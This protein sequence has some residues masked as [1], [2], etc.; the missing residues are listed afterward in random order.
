MGGHMAQ[1]IA[2]LFL[3]S[4]FSSFLPAQESSIQAGIVQFIEGETFMDGNIFQLAKDSIRL[5]QTGQTLSTKQG[6]LE[7][8]LASNTNLSLGENTSLRMEQSNSNGAILTLEKGSI[9]IE[10]V[11]KHTDPVRV[12]ILNSTVEIRKPGLYRLDF[13]PCDLRVYRGTALVDNGS[14]QA[15]VK[16]G[17][18]TRLDDVALSQIK[19]DPKG[20]DA[21]HQWSAHRSLDIF[22]LANP[23]TNNWKLRYNTYPFLFEN[24]NY[25]LRFETKVLPKYLQQR[26]RYVA[27]IWG[28]A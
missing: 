14:K 21:L 19:F 11:R 23:E 26:M 2:M 6:R 25:R 7:L 15:Q 16:M 9:L 20:S 3:I 28:P 27:P 18:E 5:F 8:I 12:R 1:S 17:R 13:R 4:V 24:S 22:L 10:V